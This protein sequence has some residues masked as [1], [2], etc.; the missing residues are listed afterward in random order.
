MRTLSLRL[1]LAF[2][3]FLL[4]IWIPKGTISISGGNS[5]IPKLTGLHQTPQYILYCHIKYL[6]NHYLS[7]IYTILLPKFS[8]CSP[9]AAHTWQINQYARFNFTAYDFN[10]WQMPKNLSQIAYISRHNIPN[11]A[12]FKSD[13]KGGTVGLEFTACWLLTTIVDSLRPDHLKIRKDSLCQ[14]R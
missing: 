14:T 12:S 9:E 5:L 6:L 8:L 7:W 2:Y 13:R 3:S 4:I 11:I 10:Q 1:L